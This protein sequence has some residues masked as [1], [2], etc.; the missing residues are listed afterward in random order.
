MKSEMTIRLEYNR[1]IKQA[2]E[3]EEIAKGMKKLAT[4][5]LEGC[6]SSISSNWEGENSRAYIRK[7]K[8]IKGEIEASAANLTKIAGTIRSIAK[9]TRDADLRARMVAMSNH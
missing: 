9:R 5:D 4:N 7:G 1:A 3:L 8:K 6:L 2:A